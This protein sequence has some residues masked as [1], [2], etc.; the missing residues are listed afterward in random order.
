M[1]KRQRNP[2]VKRGITRQQI[3]EGVYGY[4]FISPWLIGILIFFIYSVGSSLVYS[5]SDFV[6][7]NGIKLNPLPNWYDNYTYVF[8]KVPAF[9]FSLQQFVGEMCLKV[10]MIVAFSLIIAIMLNDKFHFRGLFRTVFFLPVVIATGPV[11]ETIVTSGVDIYSVAAFS[12]LLK[13]MPEFI[14]DL[15]S[16]LFESLVSVLWL[17]GVQMQIFLAGLQKVP[18]MQYEAA[19]I[20]GAS[21]WQSFWK[22]TVPSIRPYV[23]LNLIYSIIFL[24]AN[25]NPAID[26]ITQAA[27]IASM[28]YDVS[29]AMSWMYSLVI[30]ALLLVAF[31][32]FREKKDKHVRYEQKRE[33]I[34]MQKRAE[35]ARKGG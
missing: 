29:L 3:R 22:I 11:M 1:F 13:E 23:L 10:P 25:D 6:I 28:G 14:F 4:L 32:L 24:S 12:N 35:A 26:Q 15:F 17:S 21:P 19:K 8:D 2:H 20:D 31:L 30:I 5:F 34:Q 16:D 18:P 33:T 9:A 27:Q 7:D